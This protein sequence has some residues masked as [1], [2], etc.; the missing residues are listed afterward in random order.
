MGEMK[1]SLWLC[2]EKRMERGKRKW[3]LWGGNKG[4]WEVSLQKQW[5][6][7]CIENTQHN[8]NC[9][10]YRNVKITLILIMLAM[11]KYQLSFSIFFFSLSLSWIFS[12]P[13]SHPSPHVLS[14]L[15]VIFPPFDLFLYHL[16]SRHHSAFFL[17][18]PI[19]KRHGFNKRLVYFST[20][21]EV[22]REEH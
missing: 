20:N 22:R 19:C 13:T 1:N 7:T 3:E 11:M 8:Q 10:Y 2:H 14:H 6:G 15:P 21:Q 12:S 17:L 9:D 5:Y 16:H 4:K 18:S